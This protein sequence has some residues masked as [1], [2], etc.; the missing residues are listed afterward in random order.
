MNTIMPSNEIISVD[1][2][3]ER[4]L[5]LNYDKLYWV[6]E[7]IHETTESIDI[8]LVGNSLVA[9]KNQVENLN[10]LDSNPDISILDLNALSKWNIEVIRWPSIE[11][12]KRKII[13]C[14]W[15]MID[16]FSPR[17]FSWIEGNQHTHMITS[18]RDA[19]ATS[20]NQRTTVA[21]RILW[22]DIRKNIEIES[23]EES[24]FLG[25]MNGK[26]HLAIGNNHFE[27]LK[28]AV[29]L[30]LETKYD[31][32]NLEL[33]K[34]F[35]RWFRWLTYE[36]LWSILMEIIKNNRFIQYESEELDNIKWLA[37]LKK[38]VKI[39]NRAE[40]FYVVFNPVLNTY[41]F[42]II[43]Q[44]KWFPE[45][46][47]IPW[48][49]PNRLFLESFNQSPRLNRLENANKINPSWAIK[50]FSEE[51]VRNVRMII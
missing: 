14:S 10:G 32:K 41:E 18:L 45:G 2:Q 11:F 23:A 28:E 34:L 42:K 38:K 48:N 22:D 39:D 7:L 46:F 44:F 13:M 24:P 33:K 26:F 1:E 51:I 3:R 37:H 36:E 15:G 21:G 4:L 43:K 12:W 35:E 9:F 5:A 17:D 30:F 31:P 8:H 27:Y 49:R 6:Y 16:F 50:V 20:H 25:M 29:K 19:W 40:N 47:T